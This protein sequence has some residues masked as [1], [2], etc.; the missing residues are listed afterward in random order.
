MTATISFYINGKTVVDFPLGTKL[1]GRGIRHLNDE[2]GVS[3]YL[4]TPASVGQLRSSGWRFIR[5]D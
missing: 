3:T 1:S 4:L 2:S 5:N